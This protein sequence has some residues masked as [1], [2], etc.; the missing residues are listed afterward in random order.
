M[1]TLAISDIHGCLDALQTLWKALDPQP[2]DH[3]IF[4]GDY[5]D[6]G[7]DS[8]GVI[9]FL[10]EQEKHFKIDCLCGNHEEKFVL[11]RIDHTDHAHWVDVWGGQ[12]TLDSYGP[13]GMEDVPE[14][15]WAFLFRNKPFVETETHLFVHAYLE[16]KVSIDQQLPYTLIH[17][18]FNHPL[19]GYPKPHCSG[20]TMICGHTAQKSHEPLNLGHAVCIDTEVGRGGWLTGLHVET[21]T[22]IQANVA[23][24]TREGSL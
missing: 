13:K 5:V 21:G 6:R 9:D 10:I 2:E 3:I 17:Q 7:P 12:E 11:S 4:V 14:E 1:R 20:K 24:E 22:Y 19:Y 8:K 23:G 15:H 18:K 16:A